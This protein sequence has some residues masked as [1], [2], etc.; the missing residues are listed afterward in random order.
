MAKPNGLRDRKKLQTRQ[1]IADAAAALFADRGYDAV[2]M[3]DVA[4]AAD[5]SDQTVYNHF[6]AKQD[7]VL[8]LAEQIR[9]WYDRA[10]RERGE[11]ISPAE[12]L[13]PLL[14]ADIDRYRSMA[15]DEARG[16]FLAQSVASA[17]LRRFTLEE[18]E[19]QTRTIAAA[20]AASTPDLPNVVA[21][22]HAAA[23]VAS[24]QY[25]HDQIGTGVL[26][27]APQEQTAERLHAT[28]RTA[29]D[30]LSRAFGQ[31]RTP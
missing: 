18:R 9:A 2:S 21:H 5:V 31:H 6:P 24:I 25:L 1:R 15:L 3:L 28:A 29:L 8:D 20:I 23:L 12:A 16:Q 14:E 26:E 22:L 17:A 7:L 30:E 11:A 27:Q 10:I 19:R 4:Q 13:W